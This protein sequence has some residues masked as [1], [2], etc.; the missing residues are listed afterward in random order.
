MRVILDPASVRDGG[1]PPPPT[2]GPMRIKRRLAFLT[3]AVLVPMLAFSI[4][5][6]VVLSRHEQAALVI[7]V[8]GVGL[9][10]L[11]AGAGAAIALG[12]RFA[13]EYA[14][15]RAEG[16]TQLMEH[17]RR[18]EALRSVTVEITRELN[19]D[20]LLDLFVRRAMELVG[21]RSGTVYFFDKE[22]ETL[23]ARAWVG[24]PEWL[25]EI[26]L[27]LGEGAAG[28]AVL[29][30][31]RVLVNDYK[32][33]PRAIRRFAEETAVTAILAEP[34][35]YH[36]QILGVI[37]V[38]HET[39]GRTFTEADG[40]TLALFAGPAA[41][42]IANARLYAESARRREVADA[43]AEATR[44]LAFSIDLASVGQRLTETV[45]A[46]LGV[47]SAGLRVMEPD[48]SLRPVAEAGPFA[49][50]FP[51]GYRQAGGA[52]LTGRAITERR[53]VWSADVLAEPDL[54]IDD[55]LRRHLEGSG[56]R[57]ILAVPLIAQGQTVGVLTIADDTIRAFSADEVRLAEVFAEHTSLAIQR[58]KLFDERTEAEA[59]ARETARRVATL[60]SNLPGYVYRVANDPAYTAEF[61]GEGVV[62]IT[63]YT[64]DE[65]LVTR[66]I[67]CG[68]EI[69]PD[70]A[71]P[72]WD[73]VQ[74]AV[75]ARQPY[76]SSY[77]IFTKTGELKWVWEQG[78]G[79]Y[80][81][82]GALQALEG[83]VTDVSPLKRSEEAREQLER[84]L[85][86]AQ[87][88]EAVGRLAGGIAHDFNNLLTVIIGRTRFLAETLTGDARSRRDVELID[89]AAERAA[90]LTKQLL[91]F[92]RK[93]ILEV[94]PVDMNALVAGIEPMLRR[95]LGEDIDLDVRQGERLPEIMAD[96]G[97]LDQVILN[98]AL[99]ARD[100]MPSGG[101]LSIE[102][103]AAELDD[104]FVRAHRGA[105]PG[106]H[107]ALIVTDTG[108]GMDEHTQAQAFE[109]FFTTKEVGKGT[110]LGLSTVYGVVKQ[111]NGY[112][113]IDS[114]PDAGSTFTVYLRAHEAPGVP[115]VR[116]VVGPV[117]A[118]SETVLLVEDDHEVR[119]VAR[120]SLQ[121]HG[122][123]VLEASTGA[124]ALA[125]LERHGHIVHMV[126]TDIV[127]PGMSGR[128][129]VDRI[130]QS[131]PHIR[132]LYTSGYPDRSPGLGA[133]RA[134]VPFLQK[135]YSIDTLIRKVRDALAR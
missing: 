28:M 44:T 114:R 115:K 120:E 34:L 80:G 91:A 85:R 42:A 121:R 132:I 72:V 79:V 48:G 60:V 4:A 103:R 108:V 68:D 15:E 128:A 110:G 52:G 66:V 88:M 73:L 134:D 99:N 25:P 126:I 100:A 70:D 24:T 133:L 117:S 69:H 101:R 27:A 131:H 20:L 22:T 92:S 84:D 46:L 124:E 90:G 105:R 3:L 45:R 33:W 113:T 23:Q 94:E 43:I 11:A 86:Q 58:A 21:A 1:T 122:Y 83:F 18:L 47:R 74:Q 10:L 125:V 16:E 116:T 7:L 31:G 38:S 12:A 135:P 104:A 62:H 61:I 89:K 41:T 26:R 35:L 65:Y 130:G 29:Q 40:K 67:S 30:R 71:G 36:D 32:T 17:A 9:A 64:A 127:M 50:A 112:I 119:S 129:L 8:G 102:T 93:Q 56:H 37:L 13:R 49:A 14:R 78:R 54:G 55:E 87:K 19:L 63:G 57:A 111:H 95:L 106:S 75:A 5:M 77:R 39:P 59:A 96:K 98:L 109:P 107:V 76:Q 2:G 6:V 81:E 53:A 118:G 51:V 82:D 123:V 97:Q